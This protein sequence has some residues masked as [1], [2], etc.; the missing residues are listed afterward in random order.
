MI[1]EKPMFVEIDSDAEEDNHAT[2]NK[3]E[4]AQID[5]L[6]LD[7]LFKVELKLGQTPIC[8]LDKDQVQTLVVQVKENTLDEEKLCQS[9]LDLVCVIDCSGSMNGFKLTQIQQTL[10]Y[11]MEMLQP[12]DRLAI[13]AFNSQAVILNSLR[14]VTKEN[15]CGR[16]LSNIQSLTAVGG[17]NIVSGLK[18]AY[19]I[20]SQRTTKNRMSSVFLLSDGNDNFDLVGLGPLLKLYQEK[21]YSINTFGYGDDHD[22]DSLRKM[23][24]DNRGSFYFIKDLSR[25]DEAFVDCLAL[26][27]SAVGG[28]AKITLKLVPTPVFKE[29][30]FKQ[31]YGRAWR[32]DE[33]TTRVIDIGYVYV[34]MDKTYVC[35]IALDSDSVDMLNNDVM[36]AE[37][38]LEMLPLTKNDAFYVKESLKVKVVGQQTDVVKDPEVEKHL[39]RVT[40]AT[41]LTTAREFLNKGKL[42]EAEKVFESFKSRL[43]KVSVNDVVL[44]NLTKQAISGH[45]YFNRFKEALPQQSSKPSMSYIAKECKMF[46]H[47]LNQQA[48]AFMNEQSVPEWNQDMYQNKRQKRFAGKLMSYK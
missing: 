23:A 18:K 47:G 34:G 45:Q 12:T 5:G 3:E 37:A 48:A 24:E 33:D 8:A 7:K 26:L 4:A 44:E 6:A 16:L 1:N 22:P 39:L 43:G 13:V 17:T 9:S 40:G 11:L 30:S 29:I 10:V 27:T 20:L 31:C 42:E 41:V 28:R 14:L 38:S 21:N 19:Q 25:V 2:E 36:I 46:S 35:E 15:K 32:G